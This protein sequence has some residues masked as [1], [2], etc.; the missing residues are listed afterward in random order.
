MTE[1]GLQACYG[2]TLYL[3]GFPICEPERRAS[4][5]HHAVPDQA[6]DPEGRMTARRPRRAR[7]MWQSSSS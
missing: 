3:Q 6:R 1:S 5:V 4:P 2:K 7:P